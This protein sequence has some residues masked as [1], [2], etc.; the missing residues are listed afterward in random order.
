MNSRTVRVE[1]KD[2]HVILILTKQKGYG[3]VKNSN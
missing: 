1:L 3:Q 2:N